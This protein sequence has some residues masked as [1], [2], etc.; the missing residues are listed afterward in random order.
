MRRLELDRYF[1]ITSLSGT[2]AY[3]PIEETVNIHLHI[4]LSDETGACL[5]GHLLEGSVVWTTAEVTIL[6]S[7]SHRFLRKL[8][9]STGFRELVVAA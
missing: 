6:E 4:S 2:L 5:G 8:D 3:D 9:N 7:K 1:E